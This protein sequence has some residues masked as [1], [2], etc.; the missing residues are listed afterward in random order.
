MVE[1]L[2]ICEKVYMYFDQLMDAPILLLLF[3]TTLY[4]AIFNSLDATIRSSNSLDPDQARHFVGCDL[5]RNCLQMTKVAA[6]EQ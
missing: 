6:S 4:C 3:L 5:G 2:H 1:K